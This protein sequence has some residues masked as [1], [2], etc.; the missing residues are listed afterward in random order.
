MKR[1]VTIPNSHP[2][3]ASLMGREK[4]VSGYKNG[5]VAIEGLIAHGR[6]ECF[7]YL[8]GERTTDSAKL[9][10]NTAA[11]QLLVS[12]YPVISI[13]GN[14]AALCSETVCS[15]HRSIIKSMLEINLFYYTK[16]RE[17]SIAA[18]LKNYGVDNILGT[19]PENLIKIP[20]LESNRRLVDRKGIFKS[21]TVLVPLEDGDR[22]LALKKMGKT[23]ITI[24]LNPLSRTSLTADITIVDN[25]IRAIPLLIERIQHH[26]KNSS[27][28]YLQQLISRFDNK[29]GLNDALSIMSNNR[30]T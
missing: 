18:E 1:E 30:V 9:A 13:N 25:V 23:V 27:N 16:E 8:I 4:I 21:D 20:E 14:V 10:I 6:G 7:D 19:N 26:K 3:Y 28:E 29:K 24:D 17:A 11:A 2:R 15:L 22:T 12:V 5:L